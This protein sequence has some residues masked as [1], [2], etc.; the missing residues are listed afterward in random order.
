V[1]EDL[2]RVVADCL[3]D[4][5]LPVERIDAFCETHKM[6]R[7]DFAF[8]FAKA[9]ALGFAEGSLA[10]WPCDHAMNRLAGALRHEFDGFAWEIFQA[11]DDG[12]FTHSGDPPGT[13]QWQRYTVPQ[14]MSAITS[15]GLKPPA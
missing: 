3:K 11:F 15:A 4:V 14:V 13:I 12:E 1:E 6:T 9:I 10:F 5:P 2:S 8:L 7:A